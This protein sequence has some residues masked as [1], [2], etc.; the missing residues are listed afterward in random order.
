MTG[1]YI[2]NTN[3]ISA[4]ITR[5]SSGAYILSTDGIHANYVGRSDNDI[6]NRLGS[7]V[8]QGYSHFWFEY[9]TSPMQAFNLECS[10]WHSYQNLN[11]TVHPARPNNS[12]WQCPRCNIFQ[13]P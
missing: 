2:L 1:P 13:T 12:G 10:L 9:T 3:T 4:T 5:V 11:N 7:W 6:A 8:N